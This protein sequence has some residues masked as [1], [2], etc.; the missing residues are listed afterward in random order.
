MKK[1]IYTAVLVCSVFFAAHSQ[2]SVDVRIKEVY[3]EHV[4]SIV[5]SDPDLL[6]ALN[7][8]LQNRVKIIES[9]IDTEEKY[10]KLSQVDLL[11]IYNP[12]LKRDLFFDPSNFNVLKYNLNFF[13]TKLTYVYRVD[14]T[15]YLIVIEPQVIN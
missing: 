5:L 15:N 8:L 6:K 7:D 2:E 11:N 4:Q 9:A 14:N 3:G 13:S 1:V 10:T 12:G